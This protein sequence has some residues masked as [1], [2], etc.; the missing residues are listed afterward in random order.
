MRY[1]KFAA[2]NTFF[3]LSKAR[4]T[5]L[6][7][8]KKNEDHGFQ[9]THCSKDNSFAQTAYFIEGFFPVSG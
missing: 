8:E 7:E 1:G 9:A 4:S 3:H 5:C 2:A 6:E